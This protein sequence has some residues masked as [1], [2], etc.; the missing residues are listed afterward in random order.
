[1]NE[2]PLYDLL[3]IISSLRSLR[4]GVGW[5]LLQELLQIKDTHRPRALP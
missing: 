3:V 4:E 5:S 2:V 1:M